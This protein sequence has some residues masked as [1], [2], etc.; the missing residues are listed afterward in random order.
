MFLENAMQRPFPELAFGSTGFQ[1]VILSLHVVSMNRKQ[2]LVLKEIQIKQFER[3]AQEC[4]QDFDAHYK[5]ARAYD[6]EDSLGAALKE[7]E[8]ASSLAP[9]VTQVKFE[10]GVVYIRQKVLDMAARQL[11][12]MV[13][14][15]GDFKFDEISY[16]RYGSL[17]MALREMK[18]FQAAAGENAYQHYTIGFAYSCLGQIALALEEFDE[19]LRINPKLE[20]AYYHKGLCF[21][22]IGKFNEAVQEFLAELSIRQ[23]NPNACYW[24][25]MALMEQGRNFQALQQFKR[26]LDIKPRY[27]KALYM[28]GAAYSKQGQDEDALRCLNRVLEIDK[29]F[30]RAHLELGRISEK[31][32]KMDDAIAEYKKASDLDPALKDAHIRLGMLYRNIGKSELALQEFEK[33]IELDSTEADAYYY[34]GVTYSQLGK[35]REAVRSLKK[36]LELNPSNNSARYSLG[37][38]YF[39]IGDLDK[40][41]EEYNRILEINPRETQVRNSLGLAYFRKDQLTL[42]INQF[43]KVVESNARDAYAHYHLGTAYFKLNQLDQAIEEYMKAA[44][45][46]PDS[47]YA[48]FSLGATYSRSGN[49]DLAVEE[50]QKGTELMPAN[51]ADLAKFATM[52]LLAAIGVEHAKQG[53]RMQ[54]LYT[55]I[56]EAYLATVKVLAKTVDARDSYTKFHSERV[57]KICVRLAKELGLSD[58]DIHELEIAAYL[59]DI[60]KLGIPDS[61]LHKESALLEEEKIVMR[62]HPMIGF[63]MLEDMPFLKN[64]LSAIK[65]H[66]ER[67]DGTGYPEGLKGDAIPLPAKIMAVADVFDALVTNRP[68]RDALSPQKALDEMVKM[69]GTQLAPEAVDAFAKVLDDLILIL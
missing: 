38:A 45:L 24:M 60:G 25:G 63:K 52:Q 11:Q 34:S 6:E 32:F 65:Y 15:D 22:R 13:D 30:P 20:A 43:L 41:I 48:R 56:D 21:F 53:R 29:N 31:Q 39:K 5:L 44:E 67:I 26:A 64:I 7:Y 23:N 50:F 55:Q 3:M 49:Y 35:N 8:K 17:Q 28:L 4:P 37:L 19:A 47:V 27:V 62:N 57:S 69:K 42:A 61:I 12:K 33:T 59:H 66:H 68:Y 54:E 2:V 1:P 10:L 18:E 9:S 51:E 58:A 46:N 40:A 16:D 14:D 36:A